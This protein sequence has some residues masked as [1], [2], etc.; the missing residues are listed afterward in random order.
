MA[1]WPLERATWTIPIVMAIAGDPVGEGFADWRGWWEP[2]RKFCRCRPDHDEEDAEPQGGRPGLPR[3]TPHN[4]EGPARAAVTETEAAVRTGTPADDDAGGEPGEVGSGL[5]H[6]AR[7]RCG[8]RRRGPG[9]SYPYREAIFFSR[10]C[11]ASLPTVSGRSGNRRGGG[12][13]AHGGWMPNW[14]CIV[15][16]PAT[17]TRSSRAPSRHTPMDQPIK[18]ELVINRESEKATCPAGVSPAGL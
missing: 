1:I 10:R 6:G 16:P 17:S 11:A 12:L 18:F 8:G 3:G 2:H 15:A 4:R 7:Y 13:L 14:T 9:T 5:H